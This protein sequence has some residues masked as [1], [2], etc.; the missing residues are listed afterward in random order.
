MKPLDPEKMI[1]VVQRALER[2]NLKKGLALYEESQQFTLGLSL[3][4]LEIVSRPRTTLVSPLEW[5][6]DD[7]SWKDDYSNPA[8]LSPEELARRRAEF[9]AAK[10]TVN[11]S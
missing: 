8:R 7:D 11:K 1:I 2:Y 9:D 5:K 4:A 3:S 10:Q 6:A